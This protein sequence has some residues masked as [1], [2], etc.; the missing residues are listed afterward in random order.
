MRHRLLRR[1]WRSPRQREDRCPTLRQLVETAQKELRREHD[2]LVPIGAKNATFPIN[3]GYL[4]RTGPISVIS[5][6]RLSDLDDRLDLGSICVLND[7]AAFGNDV[8]HGGTV[9]RS[10]N[11]FGC[12][13]RRIR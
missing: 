2:R 3:P 9:W 13:Y 11:A 5:F 1:D 6:G 4:D 12:T 10:R 8:V 7:D